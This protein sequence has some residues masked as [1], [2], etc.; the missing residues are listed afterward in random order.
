M[1]KSHPPLFLPSLT[2]FPPFFSGPAQNPGDS[3]EAGGG[4]FYGK[5]LKP[6]DPWRARWKRRWGRGGWSGASPLLARLLGAA[7]LV[8]VLFAAASLCPGRE[9]KQGGELS[10]WQQQTLGERQKQQEQRAAPVLPPPPPPT[11]TTATTKTSMATAPPA[12]SFAAVR[13][14]AP[15]QSRV[16]DD[17]SVRCRVGGI[18]EGW[19]A[20]PSK[21]KEGAAAAR[22]SHSTHSTSA[23]PKI[24][25]SH[26]P[27]G[28][29]ASPRERALRVRAAIKD[30]WDAYSRSAFGAD[31]LAPLSNSSLAW[32]DLGLTLVDAM[33]TLLVAGLRDEYAAARAWAGAGAADGSQHLRDAAAAAAGNLP[34]PSNWP[35][36]GSKEAGGLALDPDKEVNLFE[37]TIRVLG[38]L[39][40]AAHL[41]PR[42]LNENREK[43]S[44]GGGGGGE[45]KVGGGMSLPLLSAAA[46]LGIRLS[47]AL[48]GVGGIGIVSGERRKGKGEGRKKRKG[49]TTTKATATES[50]RDKKLRKVPLSDVSLRRLE[51][52]GPA[53]TSFSSLSEATTLSMEFSFLSRATTRAKNDD[54]GGGDGLLQAAAAAT[55]S[56]ARSVASSAALLDPASL[57]PIYVDPDSGS[58]SSGVITLGARGDSYY[59]YLLKQWLLGGKKGG[60]LAASLSDPASASSD[61]KH[62]GGFSGSEDE[63]DDG[64]WMRDAFV[65][66]M[67]SLRSRLVARAPLPSTSSEEEKA[68]AEEGARDGGGSAGGS[69]DG[70]KESVSALQRRRGGLAYIR[71]VINGADSPKMDHLVC[72][73]PGLLALGAAHG[74]DTRRKVSEDLPSSSSSASTAAAKGAAAQHSP[75]ALLSSF[76]PEDDEDVAL[77]AQLAL[78]CAEMY[79]GV[80]AGLAPEIVHFRKGEGEG[81]VPGGGAKSAAAKTGSEKGDV[82]EIGHG[83]F[84]VKPA[85]AHN[86]LRPE[87]VE[88]WYVLWRLTGDKAYRE[89]GWAAFRAWDKFSRVRRGGG[90]G[91]TAGATSNCDDGGKSSSSSLGFANLDSV[92]E[93]PPRQRDKM[94]SF[95][96][97]ETLKYLYLMFDDEAAARLPLVS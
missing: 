43:T 11:T 7:A 96:I 28:C 46:Q 12:A 24:D 97:A 69:G 8:A 83:A 92:L 30:S 39:L 72:F 37:T 52:A 58:F 70:G 10:S 17:R 56:A 6:P 44:N 33:D 41:E 68:G 82:S 90:S 26:D 19:R 20:C 63:D 91:T 95:W 57:P 76:H 3:P 38:G 80:P 94:E 34:A 81:A 48:D 1:K 53:W 29:V 47:P 93:V 18:C 50:K 9:G 13:S 78:T 77:A 16:Y 49:A 31:E 75:P 71:E 59:E 67:R 40:S 25:E 51:A 14:R 42:W 2:S 21:F 79:R 62:G 74:V 32:F 87:A 86:L 23:S 65:N 73:L 5:D 55:L 64:P 60:H 84:D 36:S 61:E 4:P 35:P 85:D 66:S 89:W 15:R 27:L 22:V 54:D 45:D 88:S